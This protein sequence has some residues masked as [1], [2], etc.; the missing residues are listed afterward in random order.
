MKLTPTQT[1]LSRRKL[2]W[3]A[4]AT[5]L[6]A[7]PLAIPATKA[8]A[9]I[10]RK[11]DE[12]IGYDAL[13]LADLIKSKQITQAELVEIFIRRIEVINP[14]INFM[15]NRTFERAQKNAKSGT[16][17]KNTRFAG[18]P[19]LMKD[20]INIKG[21]PITHGSKLFKDNIAA[22]GTH[23]TDAVERA[24]LN[25]IGLTNV[26]EMASFIMT[27]NEL[28]G[29][30]YNPWDMDYSVFSSSGGAAAAVATG[31]VP[32]AH[33]TDGAGS[34]RLPS[35]ATG[36]YGMKPTRYRQLSG[37]VDG[38]HST[39]KTNQMISRTVRD[40]AAA[41]DATEDKSGGHYKPV[42]FVKGPSKRR[43]KVGYVTSNDNQLLPMERDVRRAQAR[44]AQLL[45]NMG[46]KV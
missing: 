7:A 13:G 15:T 22:K 10:G 35:S 20:L 25:I 40:N 19:I 8:L 45:E 12:F 37:E 46:H 1:N 16:F 9:K 31:V 23:Y 5:A 17:G 41:F 30:T 4:G 38:S 3:S 28:F 34:N 21:L 44:T 2:L 43:L 14:A 6:L 27:S 39:T 26:P 24:G 42:G 33:G 18:V 36:V 29:S 11:L 32:M